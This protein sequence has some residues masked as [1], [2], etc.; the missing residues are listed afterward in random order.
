MK[1]KIKCFRMLHLGSALSAK[2]KVDPHDPMNINTILLLVTHQNIM[3]HSILI[4][5]VIVSIYEPRHVISN[6]GAV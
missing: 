3:D 5:K 4:K 6:N 1:T 2:P